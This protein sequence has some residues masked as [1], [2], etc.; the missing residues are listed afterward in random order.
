MASA[1]S[2]SGSS[3]RRL[4]NSSL[5]ESSRV[6]IFCNSSR[7][8]WSG[9]TMTSV[10]RRMRPMSFKTARSSQGLP[11][12]RLMMSPSSSSLPSWV[13]RS[14]RKRRTFFGSSSS[15]DLNRAACCTRDSWCTASMT[16]QSLGGSWSGAACPLAACPLAT[17]PLSGCPLSGCPLS[18]G[19]LSAG[20]LSAGALSVWDLSACWAQT[21]V[22]ATNASSASSR[23][24]TPPRADFRPERHPPDRKTGLT[25][26]SA[27]S[28]ICLMP[29]RRS[30]SD[31]FVVFTKKC[32]SRLGQR[33]RPWLPGHPSRLKPQPPAQTRP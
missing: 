24:T 4:V 10:A 26:R 3:S 23:M 8:S 9:A 7:P 27:C 16:C 17:C 14:D 12:D 19:V 25:R 18:A 1:I 33:Q 20:A 15:M 6:A 11:P 32:L 2:G 28:M 30:A 31:G 29:W 22:M 13:E 21:G 5:R